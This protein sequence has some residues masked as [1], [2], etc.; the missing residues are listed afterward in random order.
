MA[1]ENTLAL[2]HEAL[3]TVDDPE[4]GRDLVSL[5]MV[6]DVRLE[7]TNAKITVE[8]TTP[9]CPLKSKIQGDVEAAVLK[10]PGVGRVAVDFTAQVRSA[11]AAEGTPIPGVRNTIAVASGSS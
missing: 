11:P 6:K 3:K 4:I 9:A 7:G 10:V 8:L 5:E 1:D 2:I